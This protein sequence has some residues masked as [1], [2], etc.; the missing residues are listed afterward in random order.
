MNILETQKFKCTVS[1]TL[2]KDTKQY[3]KKFMF[4][5]QEDT[6]WSS[7]QGDNQF[8]TI[9]MEEPQSISSFNVQFQGGFAT[10]EISVILDDNKGGSEKLDFYPEDINAV[11]SFTLKN[12]VKDVVKIQL[13][14]NKTTD[15]FGRIIIYKLEF[16]N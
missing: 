13:M 1:S 11:Q 3:G 8:I 15:F 6:C 9:Q 10:A 7:S 5:N 4:D 2:N 14:L 12:T 16:F